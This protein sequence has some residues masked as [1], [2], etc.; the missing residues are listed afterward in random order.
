MKKIILLFLAF[1][2][3]LIF[4]CSCECEHEWKEA[5]CTSPMMC[6]KCFETQGEKAEH[7]YTVGKCT[8]KQSCT[9][10]GKEKAGFDHTW[11]E[12]VCLTNQEC[13]VCGEVGKYTDHIWIAQSCVSARHCERCETSDGEALGHNPEEVYCDE[14]QKCTRCK[15]VLRNPTEHTWQQATCSKPQTCENCK[16]TQGSA[17]SHNWKVTEQIEPSCGYGYSTYTCTNCENTKSTK[18]SPVE[19]YH[20]CNPDGY[21]P[22][23]NTQFDRT[24]MTLESIVVSGGTVLRAGIFTTPEIKNKIYKTILTDDVNMPIVDL[25]G[26]LSKLGTGTRKTLSFAYEDETKQF[27]CNAEVR[28]QGASSASKP[29]KNYSIK[30]VDAQSGSNKKVVF[31]SSWGKESKYCMKANYVDYSQ[32]R[33]VVSG[34]IYGDIIE[35][36]NVKDELSS[37]PSGGAIDGFPIIVFNNGQFHGL[38][39]MNIP[40]NKW[41]FDMDDSDLKNQAILMAVDW[42]SSVAFRSEMA[43]NKISSGWELEFASNEES[44]VDNDTSWVAISMNNLIR[45]VMENDGEAFKQGISEYADVDKCIDS[46]LFTFVMCADDNISKNILW[47]TYDGKVWFSSVYDMDGTWGMK[48]NGSIE[49]TENTHK[50]S[51]LGNGGADAGRSHANYNLLWEKIYINFYDRVVARYIELRQSALS[52]ENIANRFEAFFALIPDIVREAERKKWTDVPSQTVDHL[53]QILSFA[54][55][56]LAAMDEIL[57][58]TT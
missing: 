41:M 23:C 32:A 14:T 18:K 45:F 56:R 26:D 33:N 55:R 3:I 51:N 2:S 27:E 12:Q 5:N 48:W 17:L 21:C 30:L 42:T 4:L 54:Q 47:A 57:V 15:V 31:D 25:D 36:R 8:E 37:L 22:N 28:I 58:L 9:G 29:K 6:T 53:E 7:T 38:Y 44:L 20:M 43:N 50:I 19:E 46:M 10:C 11:S 49:F 1:A 24:K 40:K 16:K 34:Q 52:Y 39:T 13:T 35:S